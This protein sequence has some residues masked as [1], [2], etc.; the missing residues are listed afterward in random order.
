MG[1][2]E[3]EV[4][5]SRDDGSQTVDK[6][7]RARRRL[8]MPLKVLLPTVAALGGGA[9]VAVGSIPD[10]NGKI[11]GCYATSTDNFSKSAGVLRVDRC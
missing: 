3:S 2:A 10:S 8:R 7:N 4:R 5:M 1:A 11:S 9:A 6:S